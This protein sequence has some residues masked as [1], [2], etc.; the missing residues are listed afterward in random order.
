MVMRNYFPKRLSNLRD[1]GPTI[2]RQLI[3]VIGRGH[4]GT[5]AASLTLS[6]SG[7]FMGTTNLSGDHVPPV[8]MYEAARMAGAIVKRTGD[9]SWDF[10]ELLSTP[11]PKPY[12]KLVRRYAR[13]ILQSGH[14]RAGWK[15]PESLLS[16]PWL[17]KMFPDAYYIYWSRNRADAISKWHV[18]D[19][20]ARWNVP[21]A[22][23]GSERAVHKRY[24]STVE[25][26]IESYEYQR[27]L[28]EVTPRPKRICDVRFEDFVLRQRETL[29]RMS[30]FL[31]FELTAIPVDRRW[32]RTAD[33]SA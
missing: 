7:V 24:E 1:H 22:H 3:I 21:C 9:C 19:D 10:D 23:E 28:V 2:P 6:A 11:P 29:E 5:R 12:R 32:V 4:G 26:R 18:T 20:L 16:L 33:A 15:L 30:A 27:Q 8:A 13:S 25:Q 31:G 14:P 17:V